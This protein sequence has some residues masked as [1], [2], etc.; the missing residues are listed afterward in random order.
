MGTLGALFGVAYQSLRYRIGGVMLAIAAVAISVFVLLSV[1][2]VR[3]E[4]RSS[5]AS[6]VSNVD[7]IVGARTGEINLLLLSIFRIG[8]P[9]ANVA[10]ESVEAIA[11]QPNV[12]W[13]VPISLGDSHKNFRVVGTTAEFFDR[14]MYGQSQ[15]LTFQVGQRFDDT[16]DVVVGSRVAAELGYAL[17]DELILSHGMAD[18]SFT[19]HDQVS[20]SITGLLAPTG[21]PVDNALFVSLEAIEAIHADEGETE[22]SADGSPGYVKAHE[23]HEEHEEHGQQDETKHHDEHSH[24]DEHNEHE[25][26]HAHHDEH[27]EHEEHEHEDE[28]GHHDERNEHED[29]H[30][31]HDEHEEH[32]DHHGHDHPPLGTVTAI[33]VGLDSPGVTLQVQRRINEYTDEALLAI[34]PGFTLAQLWSLVGGVENVLR[35]IS[36]LVF[37]SALFGLNAMMLASMRERKREIEILR[38]IGAPSLFILALLVIESLLVV[39]LGIVLALAGLI[40]AILVANNL[41]ASEL[42]I[43]LSLQV[44]YSSSFI[45][46]ALIYLTTLI[47]S[48]VP[49]WRAYAVAHSYSSGV[50]IN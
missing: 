19:H 14:Y 12:E 39:T 7:L 21:T 23:E 38:S 30:A 36:V 49:A 50:E 25:D 27:E 35:G 3:H 22:S 18:T 15:P 5:F 4:A 13:V 8:T 17:G 9:T 43:M 45:A 28:H 26:E 2:H 34:L 29:E 42:G 6:T 32:S 37:I 10:W 47:L 44:L 1:E 31:H 40:G 33:L 11:E 48:L 41:L 24:H 20:F 16:L 46:L